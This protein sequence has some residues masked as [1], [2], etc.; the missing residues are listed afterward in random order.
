MVRSPSKVRIWGPGRPGER[1]RHVSRVR[2]KDM[3]MEPKPQDP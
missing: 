2:C 1:E 3:A